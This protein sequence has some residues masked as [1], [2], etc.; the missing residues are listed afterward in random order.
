MKTFSECQ[1][2]NESPKI[3]YA[4]L[5]AWREIWNNLSPMD[6]WTTEESELRRRGWMTYNLFGAEVV[7]DVYAMY[8]EIWFINPDHPD[9]PLLNAVLTFNS[10]DIHPRPY[11]PPTEEE[12]AEWGEEL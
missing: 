6:R 2:G 9:N 10:I 12:I 11:V 4:D 8:S 7:G 3:I 1:R 5:D